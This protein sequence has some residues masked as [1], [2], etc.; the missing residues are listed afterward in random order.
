MSQDQHWLKESQV[1]HCLAARA[2]LCP[3]AGVTKNLDYLEE[4]GIK[5]VYMTSIFE[6]SKVAT[7]IGYDIVNFTNVDPL[8][9]NLTHFDNMLMAM[10]ERG[11]SS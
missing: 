1:T 7:D 6:Q 9:G 8:L 5:V 11:E 3:P 2:S 4:L 10:G